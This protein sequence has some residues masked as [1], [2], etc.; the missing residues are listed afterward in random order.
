MLTKEDIA[1]LDKYKEQFR[2]AIESGWAKFV[3]AEEFSELYSYL[4]K[5]SPNAPKPSRACGNCTLR[6]LREVGSTY[7]EAVE[8]FKKGG[9]VTASKKSDKSKKSA[10]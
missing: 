6:M 4:L 8:F 7:L 1:V 10:K 3:T 9:D 5:I 2:R